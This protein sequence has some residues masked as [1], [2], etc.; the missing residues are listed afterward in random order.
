MHVIAS[1]TGSFV[2]DRSAGPASLIWIMK[3][4]YLK[5]V[6][7]DLDKVS[8]FREEAKVQHHSVISHT[9]RLLFSSILDTGDRL[10]VKVWV[11]KDAWALVYYDCFLTK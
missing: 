1:Y 9:C 10:D 5:D 11:F 4:S 8:I 3:A 6:C 7:Q 2:V